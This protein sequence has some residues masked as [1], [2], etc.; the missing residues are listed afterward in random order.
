MSIL[1]KG[2]II[3]SARFHLPET[4]IF[5]P[6][7]KL[8]ADRIELRGWSAKGRYART[9]ALAEVE[10]TKW[11]FGR[12]DI[13]FALYLKSGEDLLMHLRGAGNWK[14]TLDEI[15]QRD[16]LLDHGEVPQSKE[17]PPI[18]RHYAA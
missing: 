2:K 4:R 9:I 7:A 15:M 16:T 12:S 5:F 1:K 3:L 8:Y 11:W 13:N 6:K 14:Y 10:D 18:P 17:R